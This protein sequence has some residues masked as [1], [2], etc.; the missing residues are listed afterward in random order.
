MRYPEA[1]R[2]RAD[3]F[4]ATMPLSPPEAFGGEISSMWWN[5]DAD[6][7]DPDF[8]PH[9]RKLYNEL[10]A[11][12]AQTDNESN[13][14]AFTAERNVQL[15]ATPRGR[16]HTSQH[17]NT[18]SRRHDQG[19]SGRTRFRTPDH[20]MSP[21]HGGRYS[22]SPY[23]SNRRPYHDAEGLRKR[24]RSSSPRRALYRLRDERERERQRLS[25][26]LE[27][28]QD[29]HLSEYRVLRQLRNS[30]DD[31]FARDDPENREAEIRRMGE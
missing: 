31:G 11:A 15:Y 1:V 18:G 20:S 26:M 30:L 16:H 29:W 23:R 22:R 9:V 12:A 8:S 3:E 10:Q 13:R 17:M 6:S 5:L 24:Q 19:E 14:S 28:L 4:L 7:N 27:L 2:G 25:E 21:L